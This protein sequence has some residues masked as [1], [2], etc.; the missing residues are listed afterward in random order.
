M[1]EMMAMEY[2]PGQEGSVDLLADHGNVL[3]MGYR[4]SNINLHSIPQEATLRENPKAY[5]IA[6][7]VVFAL[8]LD[9]NADFDF[10]EDADG[11]PVLMEVNP[12]IAATMQI[13]E[14]GGMNLPYL[15]IK[16]LL[17]ESLPEVHLREGIRMRRRYI[18]MF[19]NC[20]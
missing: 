2:L 5:D 16:Q 17:G 13:F 20:G 3:Y 19:A 18:E 15:R 12:R 9:G 4:E 6:R 14:V 8:G 1:P 10:K 7:R 11:N